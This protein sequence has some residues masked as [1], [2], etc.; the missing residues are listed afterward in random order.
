ML[1][2][3]L[4]LLFAAQQAVHGTMYSETNRQREFDR[5]MESSEEDDK[6][7]LTI[8]ST[9]PNVARNGTASQ[10]STY[11]KLG[12]A[13]NA[14]DGSSVTNYLK[15]ACSHTDLD[16]EPWWMVDLGANYIISLVMITNRGDCCEERINSAVVRIGHSDKNGGTRNRRCGTIATLGRGETKAL[17]CTGM[18]GR[19]VTVTIPDK[20][21]YLTIC[22]VQVFAVPGP[23]NATGVQTLAEDSKEAE[24]STVTELK[25]IRKHS[26]EAPNVAL[27]GHA[28]QSSIAGRAAPDK[29]ID[30]SL[31]NSNESGQCAHTKRE[32][33]PWLTVDLMSSFK[34][35]SVAITVPKDG[36]TEQLV[37]AQIRIGNSASGRAKNPSCGSILSVAPG[38]TLGF[39]CG[40]MI[41]RYV[42]VFIPGREESLAICE[43]QVFG[44]PEDTPSGEGNKIH[45]PERTLH[46]A[47][48]L[49]LKGRTT[50]SSS[51]SVFDNSARAVDGSLSS[52]YMAGH[53]THTKKGFEPWWMVE[54][55]R[56]AIVHSVAI[57]NRLDC[58]RERINGADIR[59]GNS[60]KDG[61]REN[62]RC[63]TIFRLGY[64]ETISFNCNGMEGQYVTV[65]IPN[66]EEYLSLCEV[67]VFATPLST[68]D[69]QKS[70]PEDPK[71]EQVESTS[72]PDEHTSTPVMPTTGTSLLGHSLVF[73]EA[74]DSSYVI[75]TPEQSRIIR[76]F[77]LCMRI[78]TNLPEG[79]EILL[80][81]YRT[82]YFDALNLWREK[83]GRLG[84]YMSGEGVYFQIPKLEP[85]WTHLCLA[86]VSANGRT[87]L[88]IDGQLR[89][90]QYYRRGC[91][92][93]P[94]GIFMLGQDQDSLE[95]GFDADQSF[96]GEIRDLYMWNRKLHRT[97]ITR[98]FIGEHVPESN[99]FDWRSLSYMIH[100][101]VTVKETGSL[102]Q[103][104]KEHQQAS[105]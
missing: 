25:N 31:D 83:D 101:N 47:S 37:G 34:V 4:L 21:A 91:R 33:E 23:E 10:S 6:R 84:F 60:S 45:A 3:A 73:P 46:G 53:C 66:R 52:N 82:Q 61:G 8:P 28:Y 13:A 70:K 51:Y 27:T 103:L 40:A 69:E 16:I 20:A 17:N 26:N 67:Q 71:S 41:G 29:A 15:G 100:G 85:A 105:I 64:G 62:P 7:P 30:G 88:F 12:A 39:D 104:Q 55:K 68:P 48:N 22:Q 79:R 11:D 65:I 102:S 80:F 81:S 76:A 35:L 86:W 89:R 75:L 19:Y 99:I 2:R 14:I 38:D 24:S 98:V 87:Q 1:S 72:P 32:M 74:T 56:P 78:S 44:V 63:G 54:L 59:V 95:G 18:Q 96:V 93:Y 92:I 90:T 5:W 94:G 58:C 49:A 77:T 43:I 9:E 50:Q 42:T 57:T 36:N 97:M